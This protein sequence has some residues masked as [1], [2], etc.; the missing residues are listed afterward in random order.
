MG[1]QHGWLD[2]TSEVFSSQAVTQSVAI[3]LTLDSVSTVNSETTSAITG[4]S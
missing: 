1:I 2:C 4:G 3:A